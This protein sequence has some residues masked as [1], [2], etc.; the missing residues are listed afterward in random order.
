LRIRVRGITTICAVAWPLMLTAITKFNDWAAMKTL[1]GL[2][3]AALMLSAVAF[4]Q[5]PSGGARGS[6]GGMHGAEHGAGGGHI[7]AHGPSPLRGPSRAPSGVS[8][9]GGYPAAPHVRA[10]NDQWVGHETGTNDP[11]YHLDHPWEHGHFPGPI[12]PNQVWR[13]HGGDRGRFA[14]GGFFFLVAVFDYAWCDDWL[15]DDDDIVIYEDPDHIG[16]YLAYNARLGTYVHVMYMG[17]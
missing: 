16:W 12:G 13:L 8:H 14:I 9:E 6:G 2:F 10:E 7:P 15:W 4:A 1:T 11:H 5:H 17:G 3:A